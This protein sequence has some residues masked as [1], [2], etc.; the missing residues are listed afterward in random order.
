[1]VHPK[2]EK[3]DGQATRGRDRWTRR[4]WHYLRMGRV[5]TP[6]LG[7]CQYL[8]EMAHPAQVR[9]VTRIVCAY[10]RSD[11]HSQDAPE[12]GYIASLLV[13]YMPAGRAF[14]AFRHLMRRHD[15]RELYTVQG[16]AAFRLTWDQVLADRAPDLRKKLMALEIDSSVFVLPWIQS[17]FLSMPFS[18]ELLVRI[19]DRFMQRGVQ[20]LIGVALFI[21]VSIGK[22]IQSGRR[23]EALE[24]IT[25]AAS[26]SAFTR[27][28]AR[29]TKISL[30]LE[31]TRKSPAARRETRFE[32]VFF[33][34][35]S[36]IKKSH[37]QMPTHA[38]GASLDKHMKKLDRYSSSCH[39]EIS[40]N[41]IQ[42]L[43]Y[44]CQQ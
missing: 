37:V 1:M 2:S 19:F 30:N 3:F 23:E 32:F 10:L 7:V 27:K 43:R 8:A 39:P 14:V 41:G 42:R 24:M 44:N 40:P 21:V 38:E 29:F 25:N 5:E 11:K 34:V 12:M 15:A 36:A 17:A 31:C 20:V 35:S 22:K 28:S 13:T 18:G 33:G 26:D 6:G 16:I 4:L 9:V